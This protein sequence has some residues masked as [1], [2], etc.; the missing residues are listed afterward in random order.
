MMESSG[1]TVTVFCVMTSPAFIFLLLLSEDRDV[2]QSG[3]ELVES[4]RIAQND[5][6]GRQE[7]DGRSFRQKRQRARYGLDRE[8]EIVGNVLTRHRQLHEALSRQALGH[9]EKKCSD[10]LFRGLDQQER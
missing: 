10:P 1:S 3:V 6:A 2:T 7:L 8:A 4:R 9:I 5:A